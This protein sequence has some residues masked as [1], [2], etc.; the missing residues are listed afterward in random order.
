MFLSEIIPV[1]RELIVKQTSLKNV[2]EIVRINP[3]LPGYELGDFVIIIKLLEVCVVEDT[4]T[5]FY[6]NTDY[7]KVLYFPSIS[8]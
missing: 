4:G 6:A 7:I 1:N 5:F 8:L 2:Y 3:N